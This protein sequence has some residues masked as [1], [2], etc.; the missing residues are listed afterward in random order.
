VVEMKRGIYERYLKRAMDFA[1]SSIALIVLSPILLATAL[2]VRSNLGAPVLFKQERPGK[3]EKIFELYK[4]R[5]MTD[6]RDEE[7]NLLSEEKRSTRF[8]EKLRSTSIDELPQLINI[9]KGDM[10][11]V[12]PRPLLPEYLPFYR[13]HE[14]SRHDV[15]PGL[16]GLAQI[17]G[18]NYLNWDEKLAKDVEYVSDISFAKDIEIIV[19]TALKVVKRSDVA[20]TTENAERNLSEVRQNEK[21]I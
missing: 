9:A 6:E 21:Y 5:T 17:S 14:K 2:L 15:R 4:F 3:D 7:G 12:G 1:L 18:R 19:K 10:A 8:G 20:A 11:I 16:T 13:E